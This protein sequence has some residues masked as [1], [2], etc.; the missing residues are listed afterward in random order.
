MRN[1]SKI[2]SAMLGTTK[3]R[4]FIINCVSMIL[5]A[6]ALVTWSDVAHAQ[7]EIGVGGS[8]SP[9]KHQALASGSVDPK[10][11]EFVF[12]NTDLSVGSGEFPSRLD[13]VRTYSS[14][15]GMEFNLEGRVVCTNCT[16]QGDINPFNFH[17]SLWGA[18]DVVLFGTTYSFA[19]NTSGTF[20]NLKQDGA[21]LTRDS[22]DLRFEF[23]SRDG[24][25]A[26]FDFADDFTCGYV[27]PAGSTTLRWSMPICQ[28]VR[29]VEMP[30]GEALT[31]KY[32]ERKGPDYYEFP[33]AYVSEI[34][35][36]RG[37]GFQFTYNA[38]TDVTGVTAFRSA[39]VTSST[40]NCS[41][42]T[43]GSVSYTHVDLGTA[44]P[45]TY[46]F[47]MKSFTDA[48]GK[49][50]E[51][52]YDLNSHI[53]TSAKYP[54]NPTVS[55]FTNT[56]SAGKVTAQADAEGNT[57]TYSYGASETVITDPLS[58][59]TRYGFTGTNPL[60]AY[61]EDANGNR[62][63][64]TY[65]S[66]FRV[67]RT[68][69][70]EG[71]AVENVY[72]DRGN[73][74][75]SRRKPK[76]GS[77]LADL[78][79]T[80]A[81]PACTAENYR[82]CNK[83]SYTVDHR[84]A[85]TDYA[86]DSGNGGLTVV[87]APPD[88][89]GM[90]SVTRITYA[91]FVAAAG[92]AAPSIT[93]RPN[94]A[95]ISQQPIIL[96]AGVDR[97]LSSQSGVTTN[98]VCPE[99]DVVRTAYTYVPST[100]A[101]RT[102]FELQNVALDPAGLN[103]TTAYTYDQV[104]NVISE[105][106]PRPSGD[107]ATFAYDKRRLPTLTTAPTVGGTTPKTRFTY[108]GNARLTKLENSLGSAWASETTVYD[109]RGLVIQRTG[110][111]GS[112]TTQSY[113]LA[114]RPFE[115]AQTVDGVVRR[116][117]NVLD[118]GGRVTAVR[119]AAN[120]PLEQAP[121]AVTYSN[122]GRILTQTDA[123]GHV[124]TFCYDGFD[125]LIE[126]RYPSPATGTAPT[127]ASIATGGTLPSGVT[128][129]R[130]VY[131][132]NGNLTS[133]TLRDGRSISFTYDSLGRMTKK[134]VPETDRDVSYAYDLLGRRTQANLPGTNASLSVAWTYDKAGRVRT[135]TGPYSR[136]VTY[137]YDPASAWTEVQ[138]P[139][140]QRVR[141]TTDALG[142]VTTVA[143]Q[144]A[145]ATLATYAYDELSRRTTITRGNA[146]TTT[147]YGYD[148]KY[149]LSSLAHNLAGTAQDVTFGFTYNDAGEIRTRSVANSAY[150]ITSPGNVVRTYRPSAGTATGGN[151]LNQYGRIEPNPNSLSYDLNGNL[152]QDADPQRTL[153]F[154]Y[155]SENRLISAND[156][157]L[158]YDAIGRL[159]EERQGTTATRFLYDGAYL[160]GEYDA[161]TGSLLRRTVHGP[162]ID[163]PLVIYEGTARTWLYGDERGSIVALANGS[164]TA[165]RI[166]TY[167]VSGEP[168]PDNQGRFG[169]T[170]QMWLPQ[171]GLYHFKARAYSPW[172][173]RFMQPDPIR[174]GGGINLYAYAANDP[175]NLR[176]P[177]GL[178]STVSDIIV[179][180]RN[181]LASVNATLQAAARAAQQRTA[182]NATIGQAV[183]GQAV[184]SAQSF[185]PVQ[186]ISTTFLNL[187]ERVSN[188]ADFRAIG[189]AGE[190][191]VREKII[192]SGYGIAG[193]QVYIRTESGLIRIVDFLIR[194]DDSYF[195]GVEAKA[196]TAT[197]SVRQ[198]TLDN[199]IGIQGGTIISR[200]PLFYG[201]GYGQHIRFNTIEAKV[202]VTRW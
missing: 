131:A 94:I 73:I 1:P 34:V 57:T 182:I 112:P 80:A 53:M 196:N 194:V 108:D 90:R 14:Q 167:G 97:C 176:D 173:G 43:L 49:R 106:G 15:R 25:K 51:Y 146:S 133:I 170:G 183:L 45:R 134:D 8:A 75:T 68:E 129:E 113:D 4:A 143:D 10:T 64:L 142:R 79:S 180:G 179:I 101:A 148:A 172:L 91:S 139:D 82:I 160:I 46:R 40:V 171:V 81:F 37:Y 117:R 6:L 156:A 151:G 32:T 116:T 163:E 161:A 92:T 137:N 122:N 99:A 168:S 111:D 47:R 119:L 127:C 28:R 17:P 178:Q 150:E 175:I 188:T 125:R 124:S 50:T 89:Q 138:W 190:A 144:T 135:S 61:V 145:S 78:V 83:P 103:L 13:L 74:T 76:S 12:Q 88:T 191:A 31:F 153:T 65:D 84:G 185:D 16:Y 70:P 36:S 130:Y 199:L 165:T 104:G 184:R 157:T 107:V 154:G 177:L 3:P 152:T 98:F 29:Y 93:S 189:V 44:I 71:D 5:L 24:T 22:A 132:A 56:Y 33:L 39:C 140:A 59:T 87:I 69:M 67:T 186:D 54:E 95:D 7:Q 110:P 55:A 85:R 193:E 198:L 11:G 26:Y 123:A 149:R 72:D 20:D 195:A 166:N 9:P 27:N 42:G 41:T 192:E 126:R 38:Y 121:A 2:L 23:R 200:R 35:N 21:T 100:S 114:G 201:L 18:V 30:N 48:E 136:T 105:D 181:P 96:P 197:R 60:P 141:Y 118:A 86:Y 58:H 77:G 169:Y 147:T 162:G 164:G 187:Q 155:D 128:R 63:N 102:S 159:A 66:Y 115:T 109:A 174:E 52:D 19:Q 158:V 202:I 120:T 62:T